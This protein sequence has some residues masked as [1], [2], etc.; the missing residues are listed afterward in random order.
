MIKTC[1]FDLKSILLLSI[2]KIGVS[3]CAIMLWIFNQNTL[4]STIVVCAL[5]GILCIT[6]LVVYLTTAKQ[7]YIDNNGIRVIG[8]KVKI[9]ILWE[10]VKLF[11]YHNEIVILEP[12]TLKILYGENKL[13]SDNRYSD[14][15]ISLKKYKAAIKYIPKHILQN[16]K[17]FLYETDV[18]YDKDKYDLYKK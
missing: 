6:Q 9:Q 10:D 12:A 4:V 16:K 1:G 13:L 2:L 7:V 5:I 18:L 3:F 11:S 15:H 8:R 17:L 14:I